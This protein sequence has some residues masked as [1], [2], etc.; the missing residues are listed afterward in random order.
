MRILTPSRAVTQGEPSLDAHDLPPLAV[1][2]VKRE[3]GLLTLTQ[4]PYRS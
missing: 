1:P 2:T 4:F 3:S